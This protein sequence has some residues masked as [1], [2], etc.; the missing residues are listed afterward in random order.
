MDMS[1]RSRLNLMISP[2]YVEESSLPQSNADVLR[3]MQVYFE[4]SSDYRIINLI[5]YNES[6]EAL[7]TY[8]FANGIPGFDATG[9][10]VEELNK[11]IG[12][13]VDASIARIR[14]LVR[15]GTIA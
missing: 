4:H 1:L 8:S 11:R 12:G 3:T 13:G 7:L 6:G 9:L 2:S 10:S 5:S 14:E 15:D